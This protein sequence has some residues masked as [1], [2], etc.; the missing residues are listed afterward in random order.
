MTFLSWLGSA[1]VADQVKI[2]ID[3]AAVKEAWS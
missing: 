1:A 2:V 3:L